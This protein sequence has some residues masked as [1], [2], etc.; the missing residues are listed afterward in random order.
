MRSLCLT[1]SLLDGHR[2]ILS[3]FV[4][5]FDP[6]NAVHAVFSFRRQW[7]GEKRTSEKGMQICLIEW[8][9]AVATSI[10][11]YMLIDCWQY[12]LYKCLMSLVQLP[13]PIR[14]ENI[15]L[16]VC[17]QT[18]C[19]LKICL[20]LSSWYVGWSV[21][22]SI[23][24]SLRVVTFLQAHSS[25][26]LF[27]QNRGVLLDTCYIKCYFSHNSECSLCDWWRK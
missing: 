8:Q 10:F 6:Q 4:I 1:T 20:K 19:S 15:S 21:L 18:L 7:L 5:I 11:G 12:N 13:H 14:S 23:A 24:I 9:S 17:K 25:G 16:F 27:F 2:A 26:F 3:P 22:A